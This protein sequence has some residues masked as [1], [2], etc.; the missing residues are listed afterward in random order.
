MN[1]SIID[2]LI[3]VIYM[4]V[5]IAI[6]IT[7]KRK[8]ANSIEDYFLGN[9]S[10][11]WWLL[12][13]SGMCAWLDMT[14]TMV[15]TS[16]LYLMGP[17]GLYIEIRGGTGLILIFLMLYVGKWHRRSGVIT[18]AEWIRYRFGGGFWGNFARIASAISMVVL[19]VGVLAY[20]FKGAG[21]FMSMFLPFTPFQCA[22]GMIIITTIYAIEAGFYGVVVADVF[23]SVC[24]IFGVI[25]ITI[26]AVAKMATVENFGNIASSVTGNTD[27]MTTLPQWHTS[28]PK[29]YESYSMLGMVTIFYLIKMVL[30]GAG[31]GMDPKYF[32]ARNDRE[33]GLIGFTSGWFLMLRWPLM[34]GFAI[35][36]IFLIKD[37]F[38]DQSIIANVTEL[39]KTYTGN[40]SKA[41]WPDLI[42]SIINHPDK[43]P[44]EMFAGLQNLM[45][46]DWSRKL[47]LVSYEGTVDPERI[48]PAVLLFNIPA[49]LKGMIIVTFLAAAVSTFNSLINTASGYLTR[50][51]YQGYIRPKAGNRELIYFSYFSGVLLIVLGIVLVYGTES[52]ND[53][54]GWISMGLI[55][56]LSVPLILRLYWWRFNAGGFAIGTMVGIT[57]ALAQRYLIPKMTEWEQFLYISSIGFLASLIGTFITKPTDQKTLENFYKTTRPF[58]FWK[59]LKHLLTVAQ[60]AD[61][62]REHFY[63]IISLPFAFFWMLTLLLIPMQL[64]IK[65][66]RGLIYSIPVFVVSLVGLYF[67]WYRHLGARDIENKKSGD[68]NHE[69]ATVTVNS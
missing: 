34:L 64:L 49:G 29:G 17:R 18:G 9:R 31:S 6:G 28:M 22:V 16:F 32:G 33:C 41:Q 69:N 65:S 37:I 19:F 61:V 56:G 52:I 15:I 7:Y 50:D 45:G 10:L 8:A 30:Q 62:K 27:W 25:A 66:Y 14:G 23:Q 40:I 55:G 38:P 1:L 4:A 58:G 12:G 36:G 42:A 53:I 68:A 63:D 24:I 67:F 48:I 59:P 47:S 51:I 20:S 60:T 26:M 35:L 11:P 2:I 54:W 5:L 57:A 13:L 43:Y 44:K 39:I 46:A 21:L 3:I